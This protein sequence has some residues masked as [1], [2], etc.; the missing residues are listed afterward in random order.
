MRVKRRSATVLVT[1]ALLFARLL[2]PIGGAQQTSGSIKAVQLTGLTDVKDNATGTLPKTDSFV[3]TV[4][5]YMYL[6]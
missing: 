3:S 6:T 2:I 5:I 1:T 4:D